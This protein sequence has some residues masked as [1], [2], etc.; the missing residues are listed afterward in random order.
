[1]QMQLNLFIVWS[2]IKEKTCQRTCP[3]RARCQNP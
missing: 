2:P 3:T 1:V